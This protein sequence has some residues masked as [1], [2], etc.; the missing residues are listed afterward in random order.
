MLA[1]Q[2]LMVACRI[3]R[4]GACVSELPVY[5]WFIE[6]WW[7]GYAFRSCHVMSVCVQIV[8]LS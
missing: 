1:V 3:D 8:S 5:D 4:E 7:G 2:R 6:R